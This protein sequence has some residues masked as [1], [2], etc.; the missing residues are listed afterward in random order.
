MADPVDGVPDPQTIRS[1]LERYWA[2]FTAG[3]REAWLALFT[4]GATMEDPV[5]T[6]LRT[7]RDEIGAFYDES[8]SAAD[9]V[10]LRGGIVNVCGA[11]AAF[12]M[13]V[14]P[15]LGGAPFVMDV[16]DVMSF[17]AEARI[18]SMR[19]FWDPADMRPA[20]G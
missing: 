7:G 20:E 13:E 9:A 8:R 10:E 16:I 14:R 18:T 6:P 4:D 3:D 17:D 1:T 19:A 2:A 12:T 15:T 5:G 11:E